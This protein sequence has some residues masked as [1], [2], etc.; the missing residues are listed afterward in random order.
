MWPPSLDYSVYANNCLYLLL[1]QIKENGDICGYLHF[2]TYFL[3]F[4]TSPQLQLGNKKKE[5]MFYLTHLPAPPTPFLAPLPPPWSRSQIK[6][7]LFQSPLVEPNCLTPK[8]LSISSYK[9]R[10]SKILVVM[11]RQWWERY[12]TGATTSIHNNMTSIWRDGSFLLWCGLIPFFIWA[13]F[14]EVLKNSISFAFPSILVW[15]R[16]LYSCF[17]L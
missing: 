14:C 8:S 2:A 11:G 7:L 16:W 1:F 4:K 17:M 15:C 12:T 13:K 3:Y 6:N 5:A 10:S 9:N